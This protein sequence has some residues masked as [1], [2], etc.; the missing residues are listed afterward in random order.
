M[1]KDGSVGPRSRINIKYTAAIGDAQNCPLPLPIRSDQM[2]LPVFTS[3]QVTV[4]ARP[5]V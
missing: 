5:I 3:A 1:A 2:S 4:P